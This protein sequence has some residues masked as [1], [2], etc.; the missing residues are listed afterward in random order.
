MTTATDWQPTAC[1]LCFSNCGLELQ[2]DDGGHIVG[3]RGD[4][5]NPMSHGYAC[6]KAQRLD[7]YQNTADRL[8]TPLRRRP[9]GTFEAIDWDTA[10]AEIAERLLYIRDTYGGGAF[11]GMGGGQTNHLSGGYSG[12]LRVAMGSPW[13][14]NSLAQEKTGEYWVDGRLFGH[15]GAH[16]THD[17]ERS[18]VAVFVGKN[19]WY[20]HGFPAARTHLNAIARDPRRKMIVIDPVVTDTARRADIHL[21]V[22]PGCDAFLL[23]AMCAMIVNEEGLLAEEFLAERTTGAEA[24]FETLSRVPIEEF[25]ERAGVPVAQAL[26]AAR[27]I[28]RA[29]SVA[30]V[31]DL[32]VQQSL[33]SALNS[34]LNKLFYLLTGNFS[35]RGAVNLNFGVSPNPGG[36]TP[37]GPDA[38]VTP[39][40]GHKLISNIVPCAVLPDEILT[41]HPARFR[42]MWVGGANPAV[43][44]PD[45]LRQAE[46]LAALELLV[47]VD[48]AMT[49]TARLAHYVLPATTQF[50]KWECSMLYLRSTFPDN[51][52]HLRAPV[53]PPR[54]G[55]LPEPEIARRLIRA[56]G[57]LTDDLADL[58]TAAAEGRE[59]FAAAFAKASAEREQVGRYA[60][61]VLYETLGPTLPDGAAAAATLW[62]LAHGIAASSPEAVRRAG[63]EGEGR[64][65]GEALFDAIL[66][67]RSGIQLTVHE[68]E[69]NWKR[70]RHEDG[71][72]HLAIE[73]MLAEIEALRD[74]PPPEN[75]EFPF[76][77]AAGQR[78]SSNANSIMRDPA[79]RRGDRVGT[80]RIHPDDAAGLG[81]ADGVQARVTSVRASVE[82]E[83]ETT[84]AVPAGYVTLP[85]GF[86]MIYPDEHGVERTHGP[87]VNELTDA[88]HRCPIAGTPY[89]KYVPVRIEAVTD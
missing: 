43:T 41:D 55:A 62:P 75:P 67:G 23:A 33:H 39:V 51:T 8:E 73:E 48:V 70:I 44:Y 18:E 84:D 45:S 52:F 54:A 27:V 25:C 60:P 1:V 2:V 89:H 66:A 85:H 37:E 56:M 14:V 40:T 9:D 49:E 38:P 6:E 16:T 53:L 12:A 13:G 58:H 79:W 7:H 77:L 46:A 34:Y 20:S 22:R 78:R 81:L 64:A 28:G 31:E 72:I 21:R 76:V 88:E 32:G 26:E 61:I 87:Q 30:V 35:R 69:D 4:K 63:H 10:I 74:E 5:A 42:A 15:Q 80:L 57:E 17:L 47:V 50:E 86:G 29:E 19:P 59:A 82:A 11:I 71:R 68:Y 3:V 83:V 36:H 24:V 65:L